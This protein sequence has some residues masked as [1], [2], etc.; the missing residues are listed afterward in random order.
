[1]NPGV[2]WTNKAG[3]Q[4]LEPSSSDGPSSTIPP[5]L[6]AHRR[7]SKCFGEVQ[8]GLGRLWA[9]R[10]RRDDLQEIETLPSIKPGGTQASK[11]SSRKQEPGKDPRQQAGKL[12][13]RSGR[14]Q[15]QDAGFIVINIGIG[16]C[17]SIFK[18][19]VPHQ[20]QTC[21]IALILS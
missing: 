9:G 12:V 13:Q 11:M 21:S 2:S 14:M 6:A 8:E 5:H 20:K 18:R 16:Q 7:F 10:R 19:A 1:M 15:S 4:K 3:I 17:W